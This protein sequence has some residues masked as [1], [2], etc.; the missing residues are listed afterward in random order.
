[1]NKSDLRLYTRVTTTD[2]SE[3]WTIGC[4]GVVVDLMENSIIYE[5][6]VNVKFGF[7]E[8]LLTLDEIRIVTDEKQLTNN[9]KFEKVSLSEWMTKRI[10]FTEEE[11]VT[12]YNEIKLPKRS[13]KGSSGYDFFL[14]Y[15]LWFKSWVEETIPTGIKVNMNENNELLIS[16]RSSLGFK[17]CLRPVNLIPKIDSDY[18]NSVDCEGHIMIRMRAEKELQEPIQLKKGD[19]FCQGSFY[20]YLIT[21]DDEAEGERVGGIGSTNSEV[22]IG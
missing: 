16:P 17:Y 22:E 14:P 6:F 21:V 9:R 10:W 13:T 8:Y 2:E 5:N 18:Y 20:E 11:W 7:G 4:E 15:S 12:I 1:M 3:H 19:A